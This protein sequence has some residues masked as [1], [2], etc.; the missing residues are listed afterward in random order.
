[1]T[2]GTGVRRGHTC[3]E[4]LALTLDR[5]DIR[6]RNGGFHTLDDLFRRKETTRVT[7][8]AL[9]VVGEEL[10]IDAGLVNR[11]VANAA[12]LRAIGDELLG[13]GRRTALQIFIG[14]QMI[15]RATGVGRLG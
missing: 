3:H 14:K 12:R 6:Q 1:M 4:Q 13:V 10:G 5:L 7:R 2:L 8:D 15:D 9:A 11:H